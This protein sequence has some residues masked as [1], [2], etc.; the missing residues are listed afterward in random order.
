MIEKSITKDF[1]F[2]FLAI[3]FAS[4]TSFFSIPIIFNNI[5]SEAYGYLNFI[6]LLY[7]SVT[8]IDGSRP[9]VIHLLKEGDKNIF[10]ILHVVNILTGIFLFCFGLLICH[11]F[12]FSFDKILLLFSVCI[13]IPTSAV[14][15]FLE[16]H[17]R[18]NF[19]NS[20]RNYLLSVL[21]LLM[22]IISYYT[23]VS[24]YYIFLIFLF[25]ILLYI[26]FLKEAFKIDAKVISTDFL[27][28]QDSINTYFKKAIPS[29]GFYLIAFFISTFD[30][31]F[32]YNYLSLGAYGEYSSL[33]D[34]VIKL[35]VIFTIVR[36]VLYPIFVKTG[37]TLNNFKNIIKVALSIGMIL[38]SLGI[39]LQKFYLPLLYN[40]PNYIVFTNSLLTLPLVSLGFITI[41]GLNV[42]G[43]FNEQRNHYFLYLLIS[44]LIIV[45]YN[46]EYSIEFFSYVFL[47]SRFVDLHL[48]HT[49]S[50]KIGISNHWFF[51]IALQIFLFFLVSLYLNPIFLYPFLFFYI[52]F[53]ISNFKLI[54]TG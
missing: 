29:Y 34:L 25:S 2:I 14:W 46:Q 54:K 28:Y 48:L 10:G 40:D 26:L 36:L 50:R 8:S 20:S 27:G 39:I 9:V 31:L 35:W 3:L 24:L 16:F 42:D 13:F 22:I 51:K 5:G 32:I 52:A 1:I 6:F 49:Y 41:I 21:Y 17:D 4:L 47:F 37:I 18:V 44:I 19:A 43:N 7:F 30:K 23:D 12:N 53:F 45:F 33:R 11:L 15:G 38:S